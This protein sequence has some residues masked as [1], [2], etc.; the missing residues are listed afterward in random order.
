LFEGD[1][2]KMAAPA[3]DGD[4]ADQADDADA[5]VEDDELAEVIEGVRTSLGAHGA[6]GGNR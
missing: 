6:A 1:V 3:P 2:S 4:R 5:Y